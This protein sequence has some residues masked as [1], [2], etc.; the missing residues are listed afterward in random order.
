MRVICPRCRTEYEFDTARVSQEGTRVKCSS[1]EHVF[2][3]YPPDV[4]Q[5]TAEGR[6]SPRGAAAAV[7]QAP[8][9]LL[10]QGDRVYR[11]RDLATLQRWIVEKRVLATDRVALD[12]E[13]FE[14]VADRPE[15]KPFLALLE[16]LRETRKELARE[17]ERTTSLSLVEAGTNEPPTHTTAEFNRARVLAA[18]GE[19]AAAPAE[20]SPAEAGSAEAPAAPAPSAPTPPR[21]GGEPA[22]SGALE[23]AAPTAPERGTEPV[24]PPALPRARVEGPVAA[25]APA[26]AGATPRV[27]A[28]PAPGAPA[29]PAARREPSPARASA[30]APE[31]R[32]DPREALGG[33]RRGLAPT[34]L[35]LGI[36]G[37]VI[38]ATFAWMRG[39]GESPRAGSDEPG[40]VGTLAAQ[41]GGEA[42][43]SGVPESP[44]APVPSEVSPR[45]SGIS[46]EPAPPPVAVEVPKKPSPPAGASDPPSVAK[47]QDGARTPGGEERPSPDGAPR[48]PAEV[49]LATPAPTPALSASKTAEEARRHASA[50]RHVEAAAAFRRAIALSPKDVSLLIELGWEEVAV[51]RHG[52]AAET[53]RKAVRQ[54]SSIAGAHYGL[55]YAYDKLGEKDKAVEE[56]NTCIGLDNTAS[57]SDARECTSLRDIL[58][59]AP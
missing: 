37:G 39:G 15:L 27:P 32:F 52:E 14:A 2:T 6:D 24:P 41:A 18:L 4:V 49:A 31:D 16:Q 9:I 47:A 33:R 1:C 17:R 57:R 56:Y 44:A 23:G 43:A 21:E 25:V 34:L 35:A 7:P 8:G 11:V 26:K 3:V 45:D 48:R 28:A 42:T 20:P 50:G 51:G 38:G 5:A 46:V 55:A 36:A 13:T 40:P 58:V 59:R 12:G 54:N 29:T 30:A 53:F 19:D 10:S 22:A